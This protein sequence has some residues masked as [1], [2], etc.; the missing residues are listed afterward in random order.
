MLAPHSDPN[1]EL[2]SQSLLDPQGRVVVSV[3]MFMSMHVSATLP[4]WLWVVCAANGDLSLPSLS[5]AL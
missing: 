2:E 3:S 5:L 4:S 1:P